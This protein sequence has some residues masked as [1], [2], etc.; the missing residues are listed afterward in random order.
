MS[1]AARPAGPPATLA[2]GLMAA[3][4]NGGMMALDPATQAWS[5]PSMY[6]HAPEALLGHSTSLV[7]A[8]LFVEH[9]I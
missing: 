8:E 3:G 6:G 1:L 2:A 7:G 5:R 4:P 9:G